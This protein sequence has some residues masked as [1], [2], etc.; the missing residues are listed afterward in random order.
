MSNVLLVEQTIIAFNL[1]F[2]LSISFFHIWNEKLMKTTIIIIIITTTFS[3]LFLTSENQSSAL[4]F[5][6]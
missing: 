6:H 4:L 2:L 1:C 5:C 3:I